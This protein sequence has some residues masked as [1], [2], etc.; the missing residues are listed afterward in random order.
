MTTVCL[1]LLM[2][3]ELRLHR[4]NNYYQNNTHCKKIHT[5]TIMS[6]LRSNI[7]FL[8]VAVFL[9][10]VSGFQP[11]A[12]S[13]AVVTTTTSKL[14]LN[15][16]PP[17]QPYDEDDFE[18]EGG[19]PKLKIPKPSLS[20]P[21]FDFKEVLKRIAAL[22]ATVAAFVAIQKLGLAASEVFTP[23]LTAEQV[24]DFKL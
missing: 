16:P 17:Q 1:V 6:I 3:L 5:V 24:R 18:V 20:V 19:I 7:L 23:E 9:G 8:L 12:R 4:K 14:F 10:A 22:A 15:T 2:G 11:S 21:E 13:P